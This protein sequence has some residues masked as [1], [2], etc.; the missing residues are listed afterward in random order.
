MAQFISDP[1]ITQ[2]WPTFLKWAAG[3]ALSGLLGAFMWPFRK[4]RKEWSTLKE[5]QNKIH[6]ELVQQRTNC[7]FTLQSQGVQQIEL[8]GKTVAALDGVRLDLAEQ[9][10]YLKAAMV[11]PI[12]RRRTP[13]K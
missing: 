11:Q 4:V 6:A 10:G 9:T 2:V 5:E 1:V 12:R 8:L 7:L 3:L 13:K